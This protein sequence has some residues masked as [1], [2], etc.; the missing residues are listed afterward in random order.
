MLAASKQGLSK[1]FA[2]WFGKPDLLG[3]EQSND[4]LAFAFHVMPCLCAHIQVHR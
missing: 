1:Q 4:Y 3:K 2:S